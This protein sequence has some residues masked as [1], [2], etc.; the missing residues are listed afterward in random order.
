MRSRDSC[1]RIIRT[2]TTDDARTDLARRCREPTR[3][4]AR[5]LSSCWKRSPST[6]TRT[7]TTGSFRATIWRRSSRCCRF[8]RGGSG[9][10]FIDPPYNTKSAFEH[11]DDN[12]EHS[13]WLSMIYPRLELLRDLLAEDGSIWVTIDDNEGHHSAVHHGRGVRARGILLT[14]GGLAKGIHARNN[15]AQ[16][17]SDDHDPSSSAIALQPYA[18]FRTA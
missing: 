7:P 3:C 18:M 13:Q 10:I 4:A 14:T 16:R 6:A 15:S 17:L 1:S 9:G 8:A 5:A 12:L 2:G 11:Y